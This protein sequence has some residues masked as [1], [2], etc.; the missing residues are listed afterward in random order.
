MRRDRHLPNGL[1]LIELLLV[2]GI[3]AI[4]VGLLLPA[5][6][7]VRDAAARMKSMNNLKQIALACHQYSDA[8][9]GLYPQ[10]QPL[11]FPFPPEGVRTV[12]SRILPYLEARKSKKYVRTF[13]SPADPVLNSATL[14]PDAKASDPM[15]VYRYISYA[16]NAQVMGGNGKKRPMSAVTDGLSQTLAFAEHYSYCGLGANFSWR[17]T[18]D[19][20]DFDGE[21]APKFAKRPFSLVQRIWPDQPPPPPDTFQVQPYSGYLDAISSYSGPPDN[22][23]YQAFLASMRSRELCKPYLAQT[24]HPGGMLTALCDG[25]VRTLRG[26]MDAPIYWGLVTRN[27]G[28][29][30]GD[31]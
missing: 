26:K 7:K 8:N 17:C 12:F 11:T 4:L 14:N 31:W 20:D 24:P 5:V 16:Y 3:L 6:Q 28:E 25:S 27:G 13:L 9:D 22:T 23:P 10:E 29:V 18:M 30:L 21:R 19:E 15:S 2:I 1:T